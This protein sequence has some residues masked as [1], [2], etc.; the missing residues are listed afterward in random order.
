MPQVRAEDPS[1]EVEAGADEA[2]LPDCAVGWSASSPGE[3]DLPV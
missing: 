1:L 3:A 2:D